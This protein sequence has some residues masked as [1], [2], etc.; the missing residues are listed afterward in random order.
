MKYNQPYGAPGA[1]DPYTNGNPST[2]TK[3][4]IP[5]AEAIEYPQREIVEV[6]NYAGMTPSNADLTQLRKAI[7]QMIAAAANVISTGEGVEIAGGAANL[8]FSNLTADDPTASDVFAFYDIEG[9]H[10]RKI[11]RD[12]LIALISS[13]LPGSMVNIQAFTASGTYTK[14]SGAKKALVIVTGGGGGGGGR[15]GEGG[16]SGATAIALVDVTALSTVV[17]TIAA[18]GVGGNASISPY[19]GTDGGQSSFGAYAVAGGGGKGGN[20]WF[21]FTHFYVGVG[22]TASA[23]LAQLNGSSGQLL[24][25]Y[26][27]GGSAGAPSFWGGGGEARADNGAAVPAGNGFFGGGGG[28]GSGS[29]A[30]NGGNG[31]SGFCLVLEYA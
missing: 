28:G 2:G 19:V 20:A 17:V 16:G 9:G 18:G 22:G 5:P 14:T 6:I 27:Y 1:S 13:L 23:G 31:G 21:S 30:T 4:S 29:P 15:Y 7:S 8:K 25:G 26:G 10:H 24:N 3:G 11:T 12:A